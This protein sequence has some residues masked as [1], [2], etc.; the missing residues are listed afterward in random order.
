VRVEPDQGVDGLPA[1]GTVLDFWQWAFSD[2]CDDDI[3]GWF[4]EWLVAKLLKIESK[5]RISW[6]DSDLI[7]GNRSKCLR[8]EVKSTAYWQSYKLLDEFGEARVPPPLLPNATE[9]KRFGGLSARSATDVPK[10]S[11]L[12]LLKSDLY[13]FA[14]QKHEAYESWNALDLSQWAF[15]LA[16]KEQLGTKNSVTLKQLEDMGAG[17]MTAYEFSARGRAEMVTRG[18]GEYTGSFLSERMD[19]EA[20]YGSLVSWDDAVRKFTEG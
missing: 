18:F 8:I 2:L 15:Y 17:P 13:V 10:S 4:A 3:K 19:N 1:A 5:R 7:V 16:T 20:Q 14:L 12:K 11:D 9:T 6:A